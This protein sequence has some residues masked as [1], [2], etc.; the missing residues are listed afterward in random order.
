MRKDGRQRLEAADVELAAREEGH[1]EMALVP[2]PKSK[3]TNGG[4]ITI[5]KLVDCCAFNL[6]NRIE[7]EQ[8]RGRWIYYQG[9]VVKDT[10]N[11]VIRRLKLEDCSVR[12]LAHEQFNTISFS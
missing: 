3:L 10:S 12:K 9:K 2:P 4:K 8:V 5:N 11:A 7:Q 1:G 6:G